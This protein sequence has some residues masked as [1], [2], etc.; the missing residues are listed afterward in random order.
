MKVSF[1]WAFLAATTLIWGAAYTLWMIK[2]VVYGAV[3]NDHVAALKDIGFREGAFL[4]ILAAFV[5][6]MGLYPKALSD[7]MNPTLQELLRQAT[8]SKIS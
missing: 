1:W 3:A 6:W 2:R 5:L 8:Q 7:V 4:V